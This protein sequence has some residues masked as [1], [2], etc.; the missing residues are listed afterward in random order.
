M[1]WRQVKNSAC[2]SSLAALPA[3]AAATS[4]V[5][6]NITHNANSR[7][8]RMPGITPAMNSLPIDCSVMMP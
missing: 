5:A 7:A 1:R 2:S 3:R 4:R 8:S 6:A